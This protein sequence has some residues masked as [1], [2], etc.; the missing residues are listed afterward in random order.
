LNIFEGLREIERKGKVE[1]FLREEYEEAI[2][3]GDRGRAE[4]IRSLMEG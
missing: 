4:K 1:E 2:D 3:K